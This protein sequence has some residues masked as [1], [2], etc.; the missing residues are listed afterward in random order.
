MLY[1]LYEPPAHT[2]TPD[3]SPRYLATLGVRTRLGEKQQ[4][5]ASLH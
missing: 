4:T 3:L 5:C 1:P 2:D